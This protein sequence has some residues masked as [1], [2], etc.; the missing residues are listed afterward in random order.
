MAFNDRIYLLS[1]E[2]GI[3]QKLNMNKTER[4]IYEE[5]KKLK[6]NRD[7]YKA[8]TSVTNSIAYMAAL[9]VY[10]KQLE[11]LIE[12]GYKSD[13][14]IDGIRSDSDEP[15]G[16]SMSHEEFIKKIMPELKKSK[17][18]ALCQNCDKPVP[19]ENRFCS[20]TCSLDGGYRY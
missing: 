1:D 16:K 9:E 10:A 6:P 19:H 11:K 2:G 17:R 12:G 8:F 20:R 4:A 7:D 15:T 3:T 18:T 5:F 14:M 13:G